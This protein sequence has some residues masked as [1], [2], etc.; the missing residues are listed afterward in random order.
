[1]RARAR[2]HYLPADL[3]Y[4][5]N[6]NVSLFFVSTNAVAPR[7][8]LDR[9]SDEERRRRGNAKGVHKD[10]IASCAKVH[11]DGTSNPS[12]H[13][14]LDYEK[15]RYF[16]YSACKDGRLLFLFPLPVIDMSSALRIIEPWVTLV[17]FISFSAMA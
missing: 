12:A 5:E 4:R 13:R 15:T 16:A 11:S 14:L 3:N 10:L 7:E 2:A 17:F 9:A 8:Q 6:E 1:V